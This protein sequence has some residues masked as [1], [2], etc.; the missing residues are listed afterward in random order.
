MNIL[1]NYTKKP[2]LGCCPK[3]VF[4]LVHTLEPDFSRIHFNIIFRIRLGVPND[5]SLEVFLAAI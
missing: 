2:T 1:Q 4:F 3:P 5:I